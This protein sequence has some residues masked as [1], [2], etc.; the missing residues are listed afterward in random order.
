MVVVV[1]VV[2]QVGDILGPGEVEDLAGHRDRVRHGLEFS[3]T[4]VTGAAV[5]LGE[6]LAEV[7]DQAA[8]PAPA[9]AQ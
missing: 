7:T 5:V 3:E 9:S 6:R 2:A 8:M 1:E 4:V